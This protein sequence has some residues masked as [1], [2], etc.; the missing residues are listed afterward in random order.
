MLVMGGR[1]P[2]NPGDLCFLG[3]LVGRDFVEV[4]VCGRDS[5]SMHKAS[6]CKVKL[7]WLTEKG[8]EA[9]RKYVFS[10][11]DDKFSRVSDYL[12]SLNPRL[13]AVVRYLLTSRLCPEADYTRFYF[14]SDSAYLLN[15][16]FPEVVS[17]S[18]SKLMELLEELGL[19]CYASVRHTVSGWEDKELVVADSIRRELLVRFGKFSLPLVIDLYLLMYYGVR[20][21]YNIISDICVY[22]RFDFYSYLRYLTKQR[23]ILNKV[24]M[25]LS[26]PY[27]YKLRAA[28]VNWSSLEKFLDKI[29]YPT[30]KYEEENEI[31]EAIKIHSNYSLD[32]V[33]ANANERL[34][35]TA[36]LIKR[37]IEKWILNGLIP[38][39]EI[40]IYDLNNI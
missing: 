38:S 28:D 7:A 30:Y 14:D 6:S 10:D 25:L 24:L 8:L 15:R 2:F 39:I 22:R 21:E 32:K 1:R 31:N 4:T 16:F 36:K 26:N 34:N 9:A 5:R 40:D 13:R 3:E 37:L 11:L 20:L 29:S 33:H 17:D 23:H 12:N 27:N 18:L 19:V 35:A